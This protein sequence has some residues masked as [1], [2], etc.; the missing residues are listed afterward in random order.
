MILELLDGIFLK[1]IF[2]KYGLSVISLNVPAN[3]L[4]ILVNVSS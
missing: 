1:A 3:V 4:N 2:G